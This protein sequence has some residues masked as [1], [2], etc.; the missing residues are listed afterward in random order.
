MGPLG[1]FRPNS[2]L[3]AWRCCLKVPCNLHPH[4]RLRRGDVAFFRSGGSEVDYGA[5]LPPPKLAMRPNSLS[6]GLVVCPSR[7]SFRREASPEVGERRKETL[8]T[9]ARWCLSHRS[10][11]ISRLRFNYIGFADR[12]GIY[13][14]LE[15]LIN[16]NFALRAV[17]KGEKVPIRVPGA[18]HVSV[19]ILG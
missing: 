9:N 1:C 6:L 14:R 10:E 7:S 8:Q 12:Y 13:L 3:P 15:H 17:C 11:K 5:R 16:E 2:V 18:S 4:L 19:S